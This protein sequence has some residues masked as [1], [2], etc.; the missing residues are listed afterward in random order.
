MFGYTLKNIFRRPKLWI[1][2]F[3]SVLLSLSLVSGSFMSIDYYGAATVKKDLQELLSDMRAFGSEYN[4]SDISNIEKEILKLEGVESVFSKIYYRPYEFLQIEYMGKNYT[5]ANFTI[6]LVLLAYNLSKYEE[7]LISEQKPFT[8]GVG[9]IAIGSELA[10]YLNVSVGDNITAYFSYYETDEEFA[11]MEYPINLTV[12]AIVSFSGTLRRL[13][14]GDVF[15]EPDDTYLQIEYPEFSIVFSMEGYEYVVNKIPG[16]NYFSGSTLVID[17]MLDRDFVVNIWNIDSTLF[18]LDQ[19]ESQVQVILDKYTGYRYYFIDDILSEKLRDYREYM[20]VAR[21][22][23]VIYILP[24]LFLGGILA[25]LSSWVSVNER[26]REIALLKIKGAK[27]SQILFSLLFEAILAGCLGGGLS[28]ALGL[29]LSEILARNLIPELA[30]IYSPIKALASYVVDYSIVGVILGGI[31]GFLVSIFPART[32]SKIKI[33]DAISDYIEEIEAS[34]KFP[35]KSFIALIMGTYSIIE[36][37]LGLPL[38]KWVL[39]S[40]A[41]NT[42]ILVFLSM[43]IVMLDSILLFIG[44]FLFAYSAPKIITY[45]SPR[46]LPVFRKFVALINNKISD[47]AARNF[48]RKVNRTS[49]IIFLITLTLTFGI[50]FQIISATTENRIVIQSK[51]YV[52][53]DFMISINYASE[54]HYLNFYNELT[55]CSFVENISRATLIGYSFQA[56]YSIDFWAIDPQYFATTFFKGEF[57]EDISLENAIDELR[58]GSGVLLSISAKWYYDFSVGDSIALDINYKNGTTKTKVFKIVGFFKFLPGIARFVE[59]ASAQQKWSLLAI[60][61]YEIAWQDFY[62]NDTSEIIPNYIFV[63]VGGTNHEVIYENLTNIMSKNGISGKIL[64]YKDYLSMRTSISLTSILLF[65]TRAEFYYTLAISLFGMALIMTTAVLERKREVALLVA[66]GASK[67]DIFSMFIGEAFLVTIISFGLGT[68]VSLA[69]CY[70]L[71]V[72][73]MSRGWGISREY[74]SG[75][76]ITIPLNLLTTLAVSFFFFI[77]ITTIPIYFVLRTPIQEE[78]RVRH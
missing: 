67:W 1:T 12:K 51:H 33:L 11:S 66:R 68:L 44:P 56:T 30:V 75:Y 47:L 24:V 52:G 26:R 54:D 16:D 31:I 21:M 5:Y 8:L 18:K 34:V 14:T 28:G 73:S 60:T 57:L 32:V 13:I 63:M 29:F 46:L 58:K 62:K 3:L 64:S 50:A 41:P 15:P 74:P 36:M 9:E 40:N 77:V 19:L 55:N 69:Y 23:L 38:L 61:S 6:P 76:L 53:A 65:F 72:G 43:I 4:V 2:I 48:A 17:V 39:L 71:L 35:K 45:F 22:N 59:F 25:L 20:N 49:R 27:N 7:N 37:L 10:E 42:F 70:G 78:L